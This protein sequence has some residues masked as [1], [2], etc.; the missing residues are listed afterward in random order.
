MME[1]VYSANVTSDIRDF[2]HLLFFVVTNPDY[3][4]L[5]RAGPGGRLPAAP[6]PGLQQRQEAH[7]GHRQAGV[8]DQALL[9]GGRHRH[10]REA[11]P[12]Q[13]RPQGDHHRALERK[14]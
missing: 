7:V 12:G 13:R 6:H 4:H 9:Q 14:N 1:V 3:H 8:K 11:E 10:L 5:E 2:Y